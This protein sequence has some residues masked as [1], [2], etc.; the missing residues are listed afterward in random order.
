ML[1]QYHA[2][3]SQSDVTR[4]YLP[5]KN[6]GR[7]LI[8]ITTHYKNAKINFSSYLLNSEEQFLKLTSNWQVTWGEKPIHQKTQRYCDEIGHDIQQLAAMRKLPRK[9]AIKSAHINKLEAELKRKNMH[10]QFAKY[11]DQPHVDKE[12]SN[13]WLKSSTLKRST[14]STIAAIQEQAVSTKYTKKHSFNV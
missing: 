10:G 8:N 13:Q 2:M 6:G 12:R 1:Q 9:I 4:L 11:L 3:H 14:E 5:R 7:R